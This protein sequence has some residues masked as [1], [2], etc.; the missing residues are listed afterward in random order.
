MLIILE[1]ASYQTLPFGPGSTCGVP[2]TSTP[3]A[4]ARPMNLLALLMTTFTRLSV[5]SMKA[6]NPPALYSPDSYSAG[7][8]EMVNVSDFLSYRSGHS[9]I[10]CQLPAHT[11]DSIQAAANRKLTGAAGER[12]TLQAPE[13]PT[14]QAPRI[15]RGAE[16]RPVQQVLGALLHSPYGLCSQAVDNRSVRRFCRRSTVSG[17]K[18]LSRSA[19]SRSA[20]TFWIS[21]NVA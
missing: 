14:G 18:P 20:I 12:M 17:V 16:P 3:A 13:A 10:S 15:S 1:S 21:S 5:S 7:P 19:G 8:S 2:S 11:P 6:E 4:R 9:L